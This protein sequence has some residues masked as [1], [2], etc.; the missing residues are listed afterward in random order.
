[1]ITRFLEEEKG[2]SPGPQEEANQIALRALLAW[3]YRF[4][5]TWSKLGCEIAAVVAAAEQSVA[6]GIGLVMGGEK[7]WK[8]RKKK[9]K[10]RGK[11][12]NERSQVAQ[13]DKKQRKRNQVPGGCSLYISV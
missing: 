4:C 5:G 10:Q 11:Q 2:I 3:C 12:G 6:V 7:R 8:K 1:L 13:E 9:K